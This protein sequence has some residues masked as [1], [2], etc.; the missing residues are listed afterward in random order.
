MNYVAPQAPPE[1][2]R[3]R[4]PS[5]L[6]GRTKQRE[7]REPEDHEQNGGVLGFHWHVRRV[8]PV[9]PPEVSPASTGWGIPGNS[10]P[11][12]RVGTGRT[13]PGAR[14][15]GHR[16][17]TAASDEERG[18]QAT[19][20]HSRQQARSPYSRSHGPFN[21]QTGTSS[22][23]IAQR[24]P[25]RER[26]SGGTVLLL[27]R[28]LR[29]TSR[30]LSRRRSRQPAPRRWCSRALRGS[31]LPLCSCVRFGNRA[32]SWQLCRRAASPSS[33]RSRC[34]GSRG[35]CQGC[36]LERGVGV[37]ERG[38][39]IF[40]HS[41]QRVRRNP[42]VR[43]PATDTCFLH[44]RCRSSRP[45]RPPRS[46]RSGPPPGRPPLH[47]REEQHTQENRKEQ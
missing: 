4:G 6:P 24:Y 18:Q 2:A 11:S 13:R 3:E 34:T 20:A 16:G 37:D 27:K 42:G 5:L 8:V 45:E 10:I 22:T 40:Q 30:P 46:C 7:D 43:T 12:A 32:R 1:G 14:S 29:V 47:R 28:P 23:S 35:R 19:I 44:Y 9:C 26:T 33:G 38:V 36:L 17:R 31:R 25:A 21:G 41:L 15:R 39:L